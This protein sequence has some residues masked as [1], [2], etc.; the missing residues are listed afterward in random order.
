[1]SGD[2]KDDVNIPVVFLFTHEAKM[3]IDAATKE[4]NLN[5]TLSQLQTGAK[6]IIV[7]YKILM[8]L[9]RIIVF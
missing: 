1:M 3:L 7:T 5:V 6:N 8:E 9:C 4:P 2:G